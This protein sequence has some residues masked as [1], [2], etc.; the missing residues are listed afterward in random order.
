MPTGEIFWDPEVGKKPLPVSCVIKSVMCLVLK[1]PNNE[2]GFKM[3]ALWVLPATCLKHLS[4]QDW[5]GSDSDP[6]GSRSLK[7]PSQGRA[8]QGRWDWLLQVHLERFTHGDRFF[9][10]ESF[11]ELGLHPRGSAGNPVPLQT[12]LGTVQM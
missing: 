5:R 9:L 2:S 11:A 12:G 10:G 6:A 3:E 7:K 8:G 1:R 4:A